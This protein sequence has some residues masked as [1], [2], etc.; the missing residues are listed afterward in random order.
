MR[1]III[2]LFFILVGVALYLRF[3]QQV[4]EERVKPP[5]PSQPT[6]QHQS[7]FTTPSVLE[8]P[9]LGVSS[10]V[11]EVGM[12]SKG[13]MDDPKNADN[14]AWY[15]LGHRV[16]SQGSAVIAGHYD[17][18][19]GSQ[20]VFYR[21]ASLKSGDEIIVSDNSGNRLTY[22]VTRTSSYPYNAFPLDE[23]FNTTGKATL[24]LITCEGS[25]NTSAR[26]YSQRLVVYTEIKN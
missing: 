11:E 6:L 13:N 7:T 10:H 3:G 16:G 20:A 9:S 12:D 5:L 8:I 26:T 2:I 15:K 23:V 19:D 25:W 18:P 17:K 1:K 22:Q 4:T 21:L 14:V 24:N